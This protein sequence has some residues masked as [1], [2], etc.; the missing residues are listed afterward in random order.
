MG[1]SLHCPELLVSNL[2]RQYWEDRGL[3]VMER[4][5]DNSVRLRYTTMVCFNSMSLARWRDGRHLHLWWQ[6]SSYWLRDSEATLSIEVS[7]LSTLTRLPHKHLRALH[8]VIPSPRVLAV[9]PTCVPP[10]LQ[11]QPL[12]APS[13]KS[14]Q[15]D[16]ESDGAAVTG[17][18]WSSSAPPPWS[19]SPWASSTCAR[20]PTWWSTG[21]PSTSP[22]HHLPPPAVIN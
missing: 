10:M 5:T 4:D 22:C 6:R 18:C 19:C 11:T 17:G 21:W 13:R 1:E 8:P 3:P 7:C 15:A 16:H 20:R 14:H 9:L 12:H 2:K